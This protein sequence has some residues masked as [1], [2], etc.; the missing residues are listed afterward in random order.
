MTIQTVRRTEK[1]APLLLLRLV[2][3]AELV[4]F[5]SC[6]VPLSGSHRS[7]VMLTAEEGVQIGHRA[8]MS[9]PGLVEQ[10]RHAQVGGENFFDQT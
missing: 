3:H 7:Q 8:V 4:T 5:A 9:S 2:G 10:T 6:L 1:V